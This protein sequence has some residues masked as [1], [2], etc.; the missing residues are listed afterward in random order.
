ME[1]QGC[2]VAA[3]DASL[4]HMGLTGVLRVRAAVAARSAPPIEVPLAAALLVSRGCGW[5]GSQCQG[6]GDA[7]GG[8]A[9]GDACG[10]SGD[11]GGGRVSVAPP[12]AGRAAETLEIR[13]SR[14]CRNACSL[15]SPAAEIPYRGIKMLLDCAGSWPILRPARGPPRVQLRRRG[16]GRSRSRWRRAC[17]GRERLVVPWCRR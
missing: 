6:P 7:C 11:A 17:A 4:N 16:A 8:D 3:I 14:R 12:H 15:A 1:G 13:N 10:C 9:S 5:R 2:G